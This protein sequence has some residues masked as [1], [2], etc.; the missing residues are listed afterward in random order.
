[1]VWVKISTVTFIAYF[2]PSQTALLFVQRNNQTAK[3]INNSREGERDA[4]LENRIEIT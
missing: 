1:M 2:N 4:K 3:D